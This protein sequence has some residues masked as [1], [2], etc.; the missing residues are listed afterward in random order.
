MGD[1]P[2]ARLVADAARAETMASRGLELLVRQLATPDL[3]PPSDYQW[4]QTRRLVAEL[5]EAEEAAFRARL[6]E[7]V[8]PVLLPPLAVRRA[9][10]DPVLI[11]RALARVEEHRLAAALRSS[12]E[13]TV[14][15]LVPAG[16]AEA[17]ALELALLRADSRRLDP[18]G[19]P[20]LTASDLDAEDMHR[21]IWRIAAAARAVLIARG[22]AEPQ[23]D[24]W[25][26]VA[27]RHQL[28]RH[29]EGEGAAPAAMR[30]AARLTGQD[31]PLAAL[32]EAALCAARPGL[33]AAFIARVLGIDHA[34][35]LGALGHVDR[36]AL[37]LRAAR[38]S[39][40]EAAGLLLRLADAQGSDDDSLV[41]TVD[42]YDALTNEAA[43]QSV[44]RM[45][46][47][48]AYRAAIAEL[49]ER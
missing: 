5:V 21:L 37:L 39:R 40:A 17:A 2:P 7:L 35:A 3:A 23:V 12:G 10:T 38:L 46:L 16:D 44:K 48:P 6:A 25:I 24:G 14:I 19:D 13:R 29:D 1:D 49:G 18:F 30:L 32:I 8:P 15:E 43:T 20:L 9:T 45:Q 47:D 31:R 42:A 4:T 27:A 28:S 26:A 36:A 41:A 22:E 33:A 11:A 34:D